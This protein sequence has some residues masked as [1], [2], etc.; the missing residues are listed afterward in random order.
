MSK[1]YK[2]AK[3]AD[4]VE[5]ATNEA[6]EAAAET[7]ETVL[8]DAEQAVKT[9]QDFAKESVEETALN[10]EKG[11]EMEEKQ[12]K[13]EKQKSGGTGIA[14][15]A[16]LVALG[17]GGA[18]YFFGSQKLSAV[19]S[20]MSALS[21]VVAEAPAQA[22]QAPAIEIPNFDAEKAQIA[23]L[24]TA[25]QQAAN[26]VEQL[27]KEQHAY[28]QQINALQ[29][30]V[31]RLGATPAAD[32]SAWLFSDADFLL[33]NALRKVV[34]DNDID[35]AKSLLTEADNTLSQSSDPAAAAIRNAIQADLNTLSG[36]NEVDQ[37]AIMQRLAGLANLVDNLPMLDN[38]EE[39]EKAENGEVS[40]SLDDWQ[41]NIEK[42]ADSFLSHF[43][44]INNKGSA[45]A[46]DKG[47]IAPNQAIYLR[48]N[49]RLRLQIA[50]LAV[51]R[52]QNELYKQSLEA[53]STWVRSYFDSEN[54]DVKNFLKELD[55]LAE[56]S[57]YVDAP[58]KLQSL[59]MLEK[60]L[61][62]VSK[63]IANVKIDESQ[64]L[65]QLKTEEVAPVPAEPKAEEQ[66]KAETPAAAE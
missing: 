57:V 3:A 39:V 23:Q 29:Q 11:V 56:Q 15:L 16:L 10:E 42:S 18:G 55:S 60:N 34:L 62:K 65:E 5:T 22:A 54:G 66:P 1:Q 12:P 31:Q 17:V 8:T 21:K 6:V 9:E 49:I 61:N 33:N 25:Y 45:A 52:Q 7:V 59:E 26:R 41:K 46:K 51:P 30:Q 2:K 32:K 28:T 50:I 24:A 27:E 58:A 48:E 43:I 4:V 40:D 35:T 44:R 19:E 63:P 47:F 38:G 37:N 13:P 14:L 53:V 20:Q 36:V 64:S